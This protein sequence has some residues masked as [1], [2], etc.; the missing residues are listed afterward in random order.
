MK[1]KKAGFILMS[2]ILML[3]VL[4]ALTSAAQLPLRV[5][6]DGEKIIFP[7]AQP[8][9]DKNSR[10]QVPVRFVSEALGAKVDWNSKAQKVTVSLEGNQI[11]LTLGKKSY[12]VNGKTKQMDTVALRKSSRTFVPLRFVSEALGA[13]VKWD[14]LNY[15]VEIHTGSGSTG[16]TT[17]EDTGNAEKPTTWEEF[18]ANRNVEGKS[19][20]LKVEGF[21][22]NNFYKSGLTVFGDRYDSK[23]KETAILR[24]LVS[25]GFEDDDLDQQIKDVE[26]VIG[27]RINSKTV[28]SIMSYVKQK[29]KEE[30]KLA[31]KI[32]QDDTFKVVVI[33]KTYDDII[34]YVW[35]K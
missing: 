8:F 23:A 3:T 11:V 30:D 32:F 1:L 19:E 10:V 6:V 12:T 26:E 13:E 22:F 16:S 28:D 17:G 9:A 2:L 35:Y 14:S 33:S 29:K 7:D 20:K 18:E 24:I 15:I 21:S 5:E 31:E 25:F 34:I 4:P 27:Q